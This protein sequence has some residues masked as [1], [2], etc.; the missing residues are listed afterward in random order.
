MAFDPATLFANGEVGAWYE[1]RDI[2]TLFQD[3]AGTI[4]V[5]ADGQPVGKMLD[6]SGNGYH[7]TESVASKRPTF[8]DV[9]GVQWLEFD[10]VDDSLNL[11]SFL[12]TSDSVL[13]TAF[14]STGYIALAGDTGGG[15][16][17]GLG[18]DRG[19]ENTT[20]TNNVSSPTVLLDGVAFSNKTQ[21]ELFNAASGNG[22]HVYSVGGDY[23]QW[24]N[25][26]FIGKSNDETMHHEGAIYGIIIYEGETTQKTQDVSK[27]LTALSVPAVTPPT[28]TP[29]EDFTIQIDTSIK[30]LLIDASTKIIETT[31]NNY[32]I[33]V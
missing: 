18:R 3:A 15:R 20:S 11:G 32:T 31:P 19:S 24:S 9:G 8:R 23:T 5:T 7:A 1:P 14:T 27:Y 29:G 30:V 4:P 6:K 28:P 2:T 33:K 17:I 16:F 26:A 13:S 10:G 22:S 12:L 21:T 25:S